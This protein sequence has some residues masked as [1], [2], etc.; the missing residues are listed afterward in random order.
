MN[1]NLQI[2]MIIINNDHYNHHTKHK[3]VVCLVGLL[4]GSQHLQLFM[5]GT[6]D[7]ES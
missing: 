1:V 6:D 7:S 5:C 4:D 3:W 2:A